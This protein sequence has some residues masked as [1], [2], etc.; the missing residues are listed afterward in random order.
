MFRIEMATT[1][2]S[3][4]S[5]DQ[6]AHDEGR[7]R[8]SVGASR[9]AA[10]EAANRSNSPSA[11]SKGKGKKTEGAKRVKPLSQASSP[12][13]RTNAVETDAPLKVLGGGQ[14]LVDDFDDAD[15]EE[16]K[17]RQGQTI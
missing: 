1:G 5:N 4:T 12:E 11:K 3:R 10:N 6:P 7:E 9:R 17:V 16:R 2:G 15:F 13:G 14:P 8:S